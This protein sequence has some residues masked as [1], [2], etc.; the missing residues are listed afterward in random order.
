[1]DEF[2]LAKEEPRVNSHKTRAHSHRSH[3]HLAQTKNPKM[4]DPRKSAK[5]A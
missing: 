3:H 2:S 1:M 4:L 5:S